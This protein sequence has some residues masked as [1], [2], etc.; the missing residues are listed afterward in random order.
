MTAPS[1]LNTDFRR[2][3]SA[4]GIVDVATAIATIIDEI[5]VQLPVASR[6]TSLGGNEYQ[7]PTRE[8]SGANH[9]MIVLV[10]RT[11]ATRMRFR[12]RRPCGAVVLDGAIDFAVD[13]RYR[14]WC[15]PY[16]LCVE[17]EY[18]AVTYED[19]WASLIDPTPLPYNSLG[20]Y[21]ACCTRRAAAGGLIGNNYFYE[22]VMDDTGSTTPRD[23]LG[24]FYD[25]DGTVVGITSGGSKVVIPAEIGTYYTAGASFGGSGKLYQM[26][27]VPDGEAYK[28]SL[29]VPLDP[30]TTGT[31]EVLGKASSTYKGKLSIRK[32]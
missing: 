31:F 24:S 25:V 4:A 8:P 27:V 2:Y 14:V 11:S 22:A 3:E 29:T 18:G 17:F 10:E 30:V 28:S 23:R 26:I 32:T 1:F 5:T 19:A 20:N 15:G 6:W 16:H 9:S 21:I 13:H 12:V 7:C